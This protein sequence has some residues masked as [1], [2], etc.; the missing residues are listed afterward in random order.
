MT[1]L[2]VHPKVR[3]IHIKE[4]LEAANR[5]QMIIVYGR[6]DSLMLYRLLDRP[7]TLRI[8]YSIRFASEEFRLSLI[9]HKT[10]GAE[11][12]GKWPEKGD[13]VLM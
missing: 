12:A 6:Y 7:D 9:K 5:I 11:L 8:N 13:T 4:R 1:S 2:K 10:M 3:L